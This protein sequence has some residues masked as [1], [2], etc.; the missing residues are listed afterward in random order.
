[1]QIAGASLAHRCQS[2]ARRCKR[3]RRRKSGASIRLAKLMRAERG[4]WYRRFRMDDQLVGYL[5]DPFLRRLYDDLIGVGPLRAILVDITHVC[6]L[7]CT[8]CY[9]FEEEMD[10]R[11]APE[12]EGAF[13]A[14]VAREL[15]RG[16]NFVTIVGGEPS[17]RLERVAKL[18]DAFWATVVTNGLRR[19]PYEGFEDMSIGLSV[20]GDHATDTRLRGNGKIPVF[21]KALANY[22]NDPRAIWYYTTTPANAHEIESVVRQIVENGNYVTFNFY[23]DISGLGGRFDHRQGFEAVRREID[24][25]IARYPERVL[26]SSYLAEVVSTGKLFDQTWG[27]DVCC[28][29][30]PDNEINR[31]RVANGRPFNTHFRAYNPDLVSTRRCCVGNERDCANCYDVYAHSSW[32]MMSLKQHLG[33]ERDFANWLVTMW[34]FYVGNRILPFDD[35]IQLLPELHRRNAGL[36]PLGLDDA[37]QLVAEAL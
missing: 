7:R 24:R 23:G 13:D 33:S 2:L 32:I 15:A 29:I 25:M 35:R 9:F 5:Q 8:G 18:H 17:L 12:D 3:Q 10:R 37:A 26:F 36:A 31:E 34:V 14:F 22:K 30:T 20:W 1:M 21:E 4:P 28:S 16:T 27:Y 11:E 6:N 19:I